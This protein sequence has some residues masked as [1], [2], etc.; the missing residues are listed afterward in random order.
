MNRR[1]LVSIL[2]SAL[3]ACAGEG[4][5]DELSDTDLVF[6]DEAPLTEE[7]FLEA[8]NEVYCDVAADCGADCSVPPWQDFACD[9]DSVNAE[10]C[11]DGAMECRTP[12]NPWIDTSVWC[13]DV[14]APC[15]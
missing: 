5:D 3:V 14:Y 1:L 13:K 7:E 12:D 15:D 10:L 6:S 8:F 9:F 11:L 4:D 2:L